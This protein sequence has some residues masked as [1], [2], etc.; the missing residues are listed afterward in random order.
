MANPGCEHV[1]Y[2]SMN[3]TP[4][5]YSIHLFIHLVVITSVAPMFQALQE[6]LTGVLC[7]WKEFKMLQKNKNNYSLLV[8]GRKVTYKL[9][10]EFVAV[11]D[12][13]LDMCVYKYCCTS[14]SHFALTFYLPIVNN[15]SH[16][17]LINSN[18]NIT[19]LGGE[20]AGMRN[21]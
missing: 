14:T 5:P 4:H 20:R 21:Y 16:C 15:T 18:G 7:V 1:L 3:A 6:L 2:N 10:S 11:V 9:R 12:I 8:V 17:Y 19:F 13:G